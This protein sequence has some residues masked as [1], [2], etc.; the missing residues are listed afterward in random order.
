MWKPDVSAQCP[1]E[2]LALPPCPEGH[3][4]KG[5][6]LEIKLTDPD[7]LGL[8]VRSRGSFLLWWL[9]GWEENHPQPPWRCWMCEPGLP[10]TLLLHISYVTVYFGIMV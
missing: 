3:G 1:L 5:V 4:L 9:C 6:R 10:L 2:S 8:V 7:L